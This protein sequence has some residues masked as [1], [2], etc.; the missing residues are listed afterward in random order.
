MWFIGFPS[1]EIFNTSQIESLLQ[2]RPRCS[3]MK[4]RANILLRRN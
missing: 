2:K 1:V 4:K 3:L